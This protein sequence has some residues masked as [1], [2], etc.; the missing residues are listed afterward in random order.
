MNLTTQAAVV[1][2]QHLG[3]LFYAIALADANIKKE[4]F[5]AMRKEI[6]LLSMS[7]HVKITDAEID[8][9]HQITSTFKILYFD[10]ATS[11]DCYEE[12]IKYK[13]NNE[14]LFT[15]E[16]KKAI[17]KIAGKIAGSFSDVNKSELILLGKLSIEFKEKSDT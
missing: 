17:L 12:F 14:S 6:S 15:A 9:E 3:K 4:E 13:N 16:I 8:I 11:E 10:K 7:E 5:E 1:F 2:Y